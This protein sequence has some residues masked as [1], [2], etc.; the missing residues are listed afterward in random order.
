MSTFFMDSINSS[1][2][3]A[4]GGTSAHEFWY[5]HLGPFVEAFVSF[6]DA[7]ST[8]I[9]FPHLTYEQDGS[10]EISRYSRSGE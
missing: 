2:S 4:T 3:Y 8:F 6:F 10:Q 1:H 7:L 5:E 9:L